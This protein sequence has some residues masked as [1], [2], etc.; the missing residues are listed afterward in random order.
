MKDPLFR[1][2]DLYSTE[3]A[4]FIVNLVL[5][6]RCFDLLEVVRRQPNLRLLKINKLHVRRRYRIRYFT[7]IK[8]CC[9]SKQYLKRKCSVPSH[10][11]E[12]L[13]F[14]AVERIA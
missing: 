12:F 7:N 10:L 13:K 8:N 4:H 9:V 11:L 14:L 1:L 5:Q 6:H 3:Q 2:L